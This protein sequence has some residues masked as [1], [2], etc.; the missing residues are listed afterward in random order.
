VEC[1]CK[2][3]LFKTTIEAPLFS[4]APVKRNYSK[5]PLRHHKNDVISTSA[6]IGRN[7]SDEI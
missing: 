5:P 3:K 2:T 6:A 1:P 7:A 4:A